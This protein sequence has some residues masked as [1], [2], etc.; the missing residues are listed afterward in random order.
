MTLDPRRLLDDAAQERVVCELLPRRGGVVRATLVRVERSGVVVTT[1]ARAVTAGDDL[2][3]WFPLRGD[4]FTFE[5]SVVR[6]G[7]PAPD[8]SADG[9]L[10]GFIDGFQRSAPAVHGAESGRSFSLLPPSGRAISLLDPPAAVVHIG[11]AGATFT[12]PA[13]FKLVFVQS[14]RVQVEVGVPGV[15]PAL[16]RA[17]VRAL[18]PGDGY[19]LYDLHFV[20]V[21]DPDAWRAAVEALAKSL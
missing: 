16:A 2:R 8:R 13:D 11:A 17:E 6:V 14:G 20:E 19:L 5:A 21:E 3:V 15:P 12:L 1:A 9:V 18:S 10:L 4:T 7:V